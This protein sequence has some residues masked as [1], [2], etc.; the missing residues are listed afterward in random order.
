[1]GCAMWFM[2]ISM[3]APVKMPLK[4]NAT[5]SNTIFVPPITWALRPKRILEG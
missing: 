1:M 2:A 4:G 3:A 5:V